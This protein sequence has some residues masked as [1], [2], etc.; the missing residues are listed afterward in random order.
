[1]TEATRREIRLLLPGDALEDFSSGEP[2]I[3]EYLLRFAKSMQRAGGPVTYVAVEDERVVGRLLW[4]RVVPDDGPQE[5]APVLLYL[6]QATDKRDRDN[7]LRRAGFSHVRGHVLSFGA[8]PFPSPAYARFDNGPEPITH[9]LA[10]WCGSSATG[11]LFIG[12]GC[13]WHD[14]RSESST[15]AYET[16]CY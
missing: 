3:D 10:N 1:M 16:R 8:E 2:S 12:P 4:R 11:A 7:H 9:A 15:A 6:G 14:A 13:S 5:T